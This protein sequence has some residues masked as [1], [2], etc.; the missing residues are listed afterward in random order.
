MLSEIN[1]RWLT[2][3]RSL[4]GRP[5]RVLH[6][7]NIANNAYNNSKLFREAGLESDVIC[8]DYA[9]I[10]ACPEWE[11]ADFSPDFL[12]HFAPNWSEVD[13]HGFKRPSWFVQGPLLECVD[14]LLHP[15]SGRGLSN[16]N[17]Y[18]PRLEAIR[19]VS[20]K[21]IQIFK[22]IAFS[23]G[24]G[25]AVVNYC[26]F[27]RPSSWGSSELLR[28]VFAVS[29]M[30]VVT[31]IR[32][33]TIPAR[34]FRLEKHRKDSIVQDYFKELAEAFE[35]EFPERDDKLT[36]SELQPYFSVASIWAPLLRK[37]D[38]VI[39]YSTD[40][41]LPLLCGVPYFA[42]EHGTLRD[43]PYEN[44]PR[45]RLTALAYRLSQHVFVT[46]FDCV[47]SAQRLAPEKFTVVNHPYDEL[48]G[49]N[50]VGF[51]SLRADYKARLD[52]DFLVFHPARQDWVDGTGYADK[53]N[54]LL[55]LA[56]ARLRQRGFR[57]GL[58]AC[59]WGANV[60]ESRALL[61]DLGCAA[62]VLWLAPQPVVRFERLCLACDVVADQFKLGSFGGVT[63]KAMAVGTPVLMRLDE[64][65]LR[66]QYASLPP[67]IN[68]RTTDEIY[69]AI[70]NL[71][72]D[73]ALL[74]KIRHDTRK[75]IRDF[76][77][78]RDT[79]NKQVDQLRMMA[80]S[81]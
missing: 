52:A 76:H 22:R 23:D 28:L 46:N 51:E 15:S 2:D 60:A 79:V 39:G 37:Y 25:S 11:D 21:T 70:E 16:S 69:L 72:C 43:I 74:S 1:A 5:P 36:V 53:R 50:V 31:F 67:I 7:G 8:Y 59:E 12:D 64:E 33:L 17:F 61:A 78:K 68:C 58:V 26:Y 81:G 63:F 42:F 77:G 44:S 75:W 40:P 29:I 32:F 30:S 27:G 57:V 18:W 13:L 6:I 24:L 62:N 20:K 34:L 19:R 66:V 73:G 3:F 10:M 38:F 45:G 71:I 80:K 35:R 14:T 65:R 49:S 41:L 56:F 48:H 54:D 47:P 4:K 9:H 55:L